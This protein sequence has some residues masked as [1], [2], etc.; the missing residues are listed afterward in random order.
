VTAAHGDRAH[1]ILSPSSADR[2]LACPG[3]AL[4]CADAPRTDSKASR[5]GTRC[6]ELVE[7]AWACHAVARELVGMAL[8]SGVVTEDDA[9]AAQL[10]L[11]EY[12]RL[13]DEGWQLRIERRLSAHEVGV[14]PDCWGTPDA[15]AEHEDFGVLVVDA[16]FGRK[17]ISAASTQLF[18]YGAKRAEDMQRPLTCVIIQP[19]VPDPVKRHV[20]PVYLVRTYREAIAEGAV[21]AMRPHA[22]RS[23]GSWC[24]Y[25]AAA[26]SCPA[27]QKRA[28][29]IAQS[30]FSPATGATVPPV[31]A[32]LTPE[33]L[34]QVLT[35][36]DTIEAWLAGVR[37]R[38]LQLAQQ[39][40]P[41]PGWKLVK[42]RAGN[43][44]WA[45]EEAAAEAIKAAGLDPYDRSV[46][47]PAVAEK[48]GGKALF[49][50][51]L[52]RLTTRS[53]GKPELAPDS[54]KRPAICGP[55]EDFKP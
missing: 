15:T 53:D 2:W 9:A 11:D 6:H 27:L 46:I 25:C 1:A 28:L 3:S 47:S 7:A 41:P 52:E 32:A 51:H 13:T 12:Q 26:P 36:A 4:A 23:A 34:G 35:H 29:S 22:P 38:A 10:V 43:R 49:R 55:Q 19:H 18:I 24:E 42:G 48:T 17:P 31:P 16:K 14:H 54:D 40:D 30:D 8:P 44:K 45:D 33:Q 20:W 37:A 21:A 5:D 50:D 39:G